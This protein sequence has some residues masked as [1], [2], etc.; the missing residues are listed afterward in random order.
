MHNNSTIG[1]DHPET[2]IVLGSMG[3]TL[4]ALG[5]YK[6]AEDN[7]NKVSP[8]RVRGATPNPNPHPNPNPK[9]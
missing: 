8:Y 5:K 1:A 7:F 6:Q 3:L 9:P 4:Q 2:A